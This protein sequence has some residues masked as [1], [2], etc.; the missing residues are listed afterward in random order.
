MISGT[1]RLSLNG[2]RLAC[3]RCDPADQP[4][5]DAKTISV[6]ESR[7]VDC[8]ADTMLPTQSST[9]ISDR[10]RLSISASDFFCWFFVH[11]S[12]CT[13]AGS[14]GPIAPTFGDRGGE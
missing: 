2:T 9:E 6:F 14:S 8:R 5:S 3:Q 1:R 13:Q 11:V 7:P 4:L 12:A 10:Q